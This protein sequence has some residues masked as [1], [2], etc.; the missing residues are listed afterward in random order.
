MNAPRRTCGAFYVWDNR[1]RGGW[2][3]AVQGGLDQV[4][5]CSEHHDGG[6]ESHG[7][8]VEDAT[9]AEAVMHLKRLLHMRPLY[10]RGR[11]MTIFGP[12]TP[13]NNCRLLMYIVRFTTL[14]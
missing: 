1:R 7:T 2:P 4:E 3:T 13:K 9:F 12:L 10:D 6:D 14:C 11:S 8:T 5:Q